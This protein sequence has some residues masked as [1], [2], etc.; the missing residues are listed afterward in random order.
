M[1]K[2]G[3]RGQIKKPNRTKSNQC[4]ICEQAPKGSHD[5]LLKLFLVVVVINDLIIVIV[6]IIVDQ[7]ESKLKRKMNK[8]H[9]L[10]RW[11]ARMEVISIDDGMLYE[12]YC[13]V[14]PFLICFPLS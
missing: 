8:V 2:L 13:C 5:S 9:Y 12:Q 11:L 1:C 3:G 14:Q 10:V 7:L 6:V 4:H